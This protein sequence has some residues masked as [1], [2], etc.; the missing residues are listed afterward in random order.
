MQLLRAGVGGQEQRDRSTWL[1]V[2]PDT[3]GLNTAEK[4]L[5]VL[6]SL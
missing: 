1:A 3:G 2:E 5:A 4:E 6:W